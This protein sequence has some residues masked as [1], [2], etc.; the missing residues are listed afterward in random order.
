MFKHFYRIALLAFTM[1]TGFGM[2][3][4]FTMETGPGTELGSSTEY[5]GLLSKFFEAQ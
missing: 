4:G 3:T 1:E 5:E 2:E